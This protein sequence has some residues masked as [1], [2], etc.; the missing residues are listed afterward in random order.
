VGTSGWTYPDW[1]GAFYP[2]GVKGPQRLSYYAGQFNT[3]EVNATFYRLPFKNMI[4]G[5]NARLGPDFHL[6]VKGHRAMTHFRKL[7]DVDEPLNAFW[8]RVRELGRLRVILWQ[9]P[10]C[11]GTCVT[12]WNS[13]MRAGGTRKPPRFWPGTGWPWWQ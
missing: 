13:V 4:K 1:D 9:L 2:A 11:P 8:E 7:K 12:R 3:V 5:L 6:V 10:P